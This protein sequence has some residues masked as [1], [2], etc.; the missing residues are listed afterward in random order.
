MINKKLELINTYE[1]EIIK[2]SDRQE[3]LELFRQF[4]LDN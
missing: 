3:Q 2:K 4:I 1:E